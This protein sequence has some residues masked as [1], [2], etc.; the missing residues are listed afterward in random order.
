MQEFKILQP[1]FGT[2]YHFNRNQKAKSSF[3]KIGEYT[4]YFFPR[5]VKVMKYCRF[6]YCAIK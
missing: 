4:E 6:K 1:E 5:C 2:L 3:L